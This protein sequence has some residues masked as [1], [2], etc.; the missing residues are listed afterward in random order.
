MAKILCKNGRIWDG[1]RF[2][3]ADLLTEGDSVVQ[4][5]PD[6]DE[7]A[8]LTFDATN[9]IV[10]A[11][12]V[13]AHVHGKGISSDEF[14]A[15]M[16]LL[17]LPFGVSAVADASAVQGNAALLSAFT[18]RAKVFVCAQIVRD[19][20]DFSHALRM[21]SA[22]GDK[23]VG[24]KLYFDESDAQL[25]SAQ[26]LKD[27]VAFA[28]RHG[29]IVMVHST[30]SPIPMY[31]LTEHLRAGDILTH[32]YHGGKHNAAEDDYAC[33]RLAKA[34]GVIVD[35]GLAGHIHTNFEILRKGIEAGCPPDVLSSDV[36]KLSAYVRG[37][38]YGLT[39]CM[40]VA[41][42]LGMAESDVFR[43][44]TSTPAKALSAP[45]GRLQ[46]G[47]KADFAILEYADEE[48]A[49]L[50]DPNNSLCGQ[51]SYRTLLT[52]LDGEVKYRR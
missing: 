14:G 2:L 24:V 16:D 46:V 49:F 11:G 18:P 20:A 27:T 40:S 52:V 19:R 5:A 10:T 6:L 25:K 1:E 45:W 51:K 28:R 26:P 3:Q 34:R 37:G 32:A 39:S 12:L 22:Y 41:R 35:A 29:L 21:L 43:A 36:T 17:S 31:A 42:R 9:G 13:D 15:S 48:F 44:V 4:I 47:G 23:V 33:L 30:G 38:R 50:Q 7:K 8:D